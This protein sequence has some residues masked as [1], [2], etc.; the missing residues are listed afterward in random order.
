MSESSRTIA[1][2]A[3]TLTTAI[4]IVGV[5]YAYAYLGALGVAGLAALAFL[6]AGSALRA[7]G[8]I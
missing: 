4:Y 5:T 7:T 6:L 3:S 2:I 1:I 8:V